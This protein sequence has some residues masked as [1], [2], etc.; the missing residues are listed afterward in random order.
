VAREVAEES[1]LACVVGD[2][3]DVHD[4]HFSGTAPDGRHEDFH[5]VHLVFAAEVTD[6]AEP[7]VAETDGTTD[8]V[9]WVPLADVESGALPVLDVVTHALRARPS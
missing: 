7:R 8:A 1:G 9:A 2:L 5:G 6:D 4:L 3:L